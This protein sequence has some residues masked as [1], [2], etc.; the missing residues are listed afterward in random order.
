MVRSFFFSP[1]FHHVRRCKWRR[2][3]LR[4]YF[5][6]WRPFE[7]AQ[8]D[9]SRIGQPQAVL[10]FPLTRMTAEPQHPGFQVNGPELEL[11]QH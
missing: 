2:L 11:I 9:S 3:P 1:F 6:P 10:V 8:E 5:L 4:I 7:F